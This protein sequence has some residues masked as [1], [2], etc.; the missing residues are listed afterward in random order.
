MYANKNDI[1]SWET[2]GICGID[3]YQA[4]VEVKAIVE[5]LFGDTYVLAVSKP[6]NKP[7]KVKIT[8]CDRPYFSI[9]GRRYSVDEVI[10]L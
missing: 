2:I 1:K 6:D 5:D 8:M 9:N 3:C 7:H 10:R 4:H